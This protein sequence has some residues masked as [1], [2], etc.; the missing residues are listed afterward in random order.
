MFR[1]DFRKYGYALHLRN[2]APSAGGPYDPQVYPALRNA[3]QAI[4][5]PL[6][7]EVATRLHIYAYVSGRP[8]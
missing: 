6:H 8:C 7:G 5:W 1:S 3:V 2:R 4:L